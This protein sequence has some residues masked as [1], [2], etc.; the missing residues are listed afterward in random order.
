MYREFW[1]SRAAVTRPGDGMW[2]TSVAVGR[3]HEM[4]DH[5]LALP[6][7]QRDGLRLVGEAFE[8]PLGPAEVEALRQ[9]E[10]FPLVC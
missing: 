5:L 3:L 9:R 1:N 2:P 6:P 7:E 10:D 8:H 4:V